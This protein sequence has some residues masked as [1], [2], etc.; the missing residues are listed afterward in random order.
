MRLRVAAVVAA[1]IL[2]PPAAHSQNVGQNAGPNTGQDAGPAIPQIQLRGDRFKPLTSEELNAEQ[3]TLVDNVL[4][5]PRGSVAGPF[6]ILL[7]SPDLGERIQ[8]VGEYVRFRSSLPPRLNEFVILI[9]AR[10]WTGQFEWHDHYARAVKAGLK[11]EIADDV[12]VNKRPTEMQPDEEI[13]YNFTKEL[14]DTHQV[15]DASFKAVVDK[16][17]ERGVVDL[18]GTIGYYHIM[19]IMLN[20]D[21]YPLPAGASNP[22]KPLN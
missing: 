5:G 2:V 19:S 4:K 22:L 13:I 1:T 3:R 21:R 8:R 14:L 9:T 11:P 17:G 12:A 20:V 18:M 6:N 15:S 16:F 7:R 10:A